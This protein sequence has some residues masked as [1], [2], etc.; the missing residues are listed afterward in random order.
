MDD[1]ESSSEDFN[2]PWPIIAS[3]PLLEHFNDSYNPRLLGNWEY[4]KWYPDRP[5]QRYK[6][7]KIIAD[8]QGRLLEG[9]KREN[10]WGNYV[11]TWDLPKRITREYVK[12][13]VAPPERLIKL[14]DKKKELQRGAKRPEQPTEPE[15]SNQ[16]LPVLDYSSPARR[17]FQRRNESSSALDLRPHT[18]KLEPLVKPLESKQ[19]VRPTSLDERIKNILESVEKKSEHNSLAREIFPEIKALPKH[20]REKDVLPSATDS[21]GLSKFV[22]ETNGYEKALNEHLNRYEEVCDDESGEERPPDLIQFDEAEPDIKMKQMPVVEKPHTP[23]AQIAKRYHEENLRHKPLPDVVDDPV[24]KALTSSGHDNPGGSLAVEAMPSAV[25]WKCYSVPGP[26]ECSKLKVYRPKTA[27]DGMKS[28]KD[29]RPKTSISKEQKK[30]RFLPIDLAI[31]WDLKSDESSNET[32]KSPHIDGSN[33]SAAPAVF[34]MIRPRETLEDEQN[35]LT[36]WQ[37]MSEK[38]P[39]SINEDN[40]ANLPSQLENKQ[41]TPQSATVNKDAIMTCI[42]T[43][44]TEKKGSP[45]PTSTNSISTNAAEYARQNPKTAWS[46][47]DTGKALS[48]KLLQLQNTKRVHPTES[49]ELSCSWDSLQANRK[50]LHQSTPNLSSVTQDCKDSTSTK[51]RQKVGPKG[52]QCSACGKLNSPPVD[53]RQEK[54]EFKAAFKAGVPQSE[55]SNSGSTT[56]AKSYK[57]P[58]MRLPYAKKSYSIGTLVPPFSLWPESKGQDYPEHWRLASV[59]QHSYKPIN[60]RKR[61]MLASVFQ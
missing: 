1:R 10:A 36:T 46:E 60:T 12:K 21:N 47:E 59:Y 31:C 5:R 28:Q 41:R 14:W 56:M 33:G 52:R 44:A 3:T 49:R 34:T 40:L 15:E 58:K 27:L 39:H 23:K 24:Y 2:Y 16:Y 18:T 7:T 43:P 22:E 25:G 38:I 50:K 54:V 51:T 37:A 6:S 20:S 61:P 19:A 29:D 11:G 32:K 26:T 57:A 55:S 42:R 35:A 45:S 17:S 13:L 8:D 30:K 4:P 53:N 48:N 9:I